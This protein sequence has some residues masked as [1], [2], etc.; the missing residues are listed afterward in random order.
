MT[1]GWLRIDLKDKEDYQ[2]IGKKQQQP[3]RR[4]GRGEGSAGAASNDTDDEGGWGEHGP[5]WGGAAA[6]ERG[7]LDTEEAAKLRGHECGGV[8]HCY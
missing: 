5:P 7:G 1:L 8:E 6:H 3:Q 4:N 2:N